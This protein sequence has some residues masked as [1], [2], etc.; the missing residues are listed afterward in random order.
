MR[1]LAEK[2]ELLMRCGVLVYTFFAALA[3]F[4][5]NSW[6][7]TVL[8]MGLCAILVAAMT[9]EGVVYE[10]GRARKQAAKHAWPQA[11]YYVV[12]AQQKLRRCPWLAHLRLLRS[13]LS[14][15]SLDLALEA[16]L[17]MLR[18]KMNQ[19]TEAE[20]HLRKVIALA[21]AA[22]VARHNLAVALWMQGS[23]REAQAHM[24]EAHRQGFAEPRRQTRWERT[25]SSRLKFLGR[26]RLKRALAFAHLYQQLGCHEQALEIFRLSDQKDACRRQVHSLLALGREGDAYDLARSAT[27][28]DPTNHDS[29]I[30]L[31]WIQALRGQVEE[32]L[33][34]LTIATSLNPNNLFC[35][36]TYMS[37]KISHCTQESLCDTMAKLG[38]AV[39]HPRLVYYAGALVNHR[40]G[41]W[42]EA[43]TCS[44]A[45]LLLG[46]Q[47]AD[48][49]ECM[50]HSL[51]KLGQREG[52]VF[53][54]RF[55]EIVEVQSTALPR[56]E[57]R[58]TAIRQAIGELDGVVNS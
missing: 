47:S 35:Q 16:D 48:L 2:P 42:A 15:K 33:F 18:L 24:R 22:P 7:A 29:W 20:K 21:P 52:R 1:Q 28:I 4:V 39:A 31:G 11:F 13:H 30:A 55:L 46:A 53:L 23:L 45:A 6:V 50:G 38:G 34:S 44:N 51:M 3:P 56:R 58:I 17:G 26:K 25:L 10:V 9:F 40:L 57:E 37:L 8:V 5:L 32:A 19:P 36:E 54:K 41:N 12:L 49:L 43:C 14:P 27:S